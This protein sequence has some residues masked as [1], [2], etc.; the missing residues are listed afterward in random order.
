MD[1]RRDEELERE[2]EQEQGRGWQFPF[3]ILILLVLFGG[4]LLRWLQRTWSSLTAGGGFAP[5][6]LT[7]SADLLP[8]IIGGV[9]VTVLVVAGLR[10]LN[11][12]AGPGSYGP[13]VAGGG[14]L[15]MPAPPTRPSIPPPS[16][17]APMPWPSSG[18][19]V[20]GMPPP[21]L[22]E[23]PPKFEPIIAPGVLVFGIVGMLLAMGGWLLLAAP[24]LLGPGAL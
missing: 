19:T 5:G 22:P 18:G 21:R 7:I 12:V 24:D 11:S 10:S 17:S 4:P 9:V 2:E 6:G 16:R 14:R 15:P 20:R 1:E 3:R 23:G 8:W 13:P